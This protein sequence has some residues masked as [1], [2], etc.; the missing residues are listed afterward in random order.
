MR[1]LA[2]LCVA[3][4]QEHEVTAFLSAPVCLSPVFPWKQFSRFDC[5]TSLASLLQ[6]AP[7]SFWT[8]R[9]ALGPYVIVWM[10]EAGLEC[11]MHAH[12]QFGIAWERVEVNPNSSPLSTKGDPQHSCPHP[13]SSVHY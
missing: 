7:Y 2:A 4:I 1:I 13:Q 10:F 11:L 9:G 6:A 3:S 12:K 5:S 8:I